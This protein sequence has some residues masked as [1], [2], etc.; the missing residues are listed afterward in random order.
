[1]SSKPPDDGWIKRFRCRRCTFTSSDERTIQSHTI[2]T[3]PEW[4]RDKGLTL[5]E[6]YKT[7]RYNPS[8]GGVISEREF[9]LGLRVP[10]SF[11][12]KKAKLDTPASKE[13][14]S[15]SNLG[16]TAPLPSASGTQAA[17]F[18]PDPRVGTS[19]SQPVFVPCGVDM[20]GRTMFTQSVSP[21]PGFEA[22]PLNF[23][24][25]PPPLSPLVAPPSCDS[26]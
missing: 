16:A 23:L 6:S 11:L 15:D 8:S 20:Y 4:M 9:S 14:I 7:Q 24:V 10:Y 26:I 21:P 17:Y 18:R 13:S 2:M 25:P 12:S 3:H 22:P 5:L 1:M 19:T